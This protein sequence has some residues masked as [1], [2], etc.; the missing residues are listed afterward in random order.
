MYP[1]ERSLVKRM[2]DSPFALIGVNSDRDKEKLRARMAEENIT[3]RS[4]WNGPEGTGGPI[5]KAWGVRGW[6][7]IYVLDDQG[8]IRYKNVRGEAMDRAVDELVERAIV[9]LI[10]NLQSEDANVRSLAAFRMGKY[11]APQAKT[12]LPGLL[13]DKQPVVRQRAAVGLALLGEP[14]KP[15][16]PLLRQSVSDDEAEVR[17]AGL[18]TLGSSGDQDSVAL[19]MKALGDKEVEVRRVA[20]AALEDLKNPKATPAL[21]K[22]VADADGE[23]AK[24][25]ALSL[26]NLN[27]PESTAALKKLAADQK[28]PTRVWIAVALHRVGEAGTAVRFKELLDDDDDAVRRQAVQ[29][30]GELEKFDSTDLYIQALEDKTSDVRKIAYAVLRKIDDPKVKQALEKNV[31]VRVDDVVGQL[32]K[33]RDYRKQRQLMNE[34]KELGPAAAPPLLDRLEKSSVQARNA[35]AMAI[36]QLENPAVIAPSVERLKD[37]KLDRSLRGAYENILQSM[38]TKSRDAA[39]ELLKHDE[40]AARVSGVRLLMMGSF[41]SKSQTLLKTALKDS[42]SRV[43]VYAALGLA[44]RRNS[45]A[46]AVLKALAND[47]DSEVRS[48]V[49]LGIVDY[50]AKT[51]MPI[52]TELA[53]DKDVNVRRSLISPLASF[54]EKAATDLIVEASKNDA[55]IKFSAIYALRQ[56]NTADAARALGGFLKDKNSSIQQQARSVLERMRNP[57]A[58]KVLEQA[59]S[60]SKTK[61][62][63]SK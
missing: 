28:H 39:K 12:A 50:G 5:S 53:K 14:V 2:K 46:L 3:W 24:A 33:V 1:H 45:D 11:K 41:D 9:T 36:G 15:L 58:R 55:S 35:L 49:A 22:A 20:V 42:S 57:E 31:S 13:K 56:Q 34:L 19:A 43:R 61:D 62:K 54:K 52:L 47:A 18:Q 23:I 44:G 17:A 48:V 30:L 51:A 32:A 10:Q 38:G 59:D 63:S 16:L 25:A 60:E 6:P 29:T 26:A 37:P 4:F 7:T 27:A 40:S 8:V 21:A